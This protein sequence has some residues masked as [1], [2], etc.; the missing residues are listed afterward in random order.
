MLEND[1]EV[2]A[3]EKG[4]NPVQPPFA[5]RNALTSQQPLIHQEPLTPAVTEQSVYNQL[6]N[7]DNK[8]KEGSIEVDGEN[9]PVYSELEDSSNIAGLNAD[10]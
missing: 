5:P 4:I 2:V 8:T 7:S 1:G 10:H 3:S 9:G 6:E